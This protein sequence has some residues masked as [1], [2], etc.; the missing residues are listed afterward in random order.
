MKLETFVEFGG[1]K[2]DVKHFEDRAKEVWK[3]DGKL[4][5]D[6]KKLAL[7]FKPEEKACYYVFNEQESGRLQF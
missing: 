4:V 6:I 3:S 1:S 5:K 2:L 7:Y